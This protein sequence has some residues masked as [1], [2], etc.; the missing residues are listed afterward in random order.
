MCFHLVSVSYGKNFCYVSAKKRLR[1]KT[2][3][4]ILCEE[5]K[6]TPKPNMMKIT[7]AKDQ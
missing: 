4:E 5:V 3:E 1:K 2:Q 7:E 6:Q